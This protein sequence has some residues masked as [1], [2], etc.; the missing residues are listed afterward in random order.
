MPTCWDGAELGNNN[1]HKN[2]MSYTVDGRVAGACPSEFPRRF[3]QIQLFVRI[4]GY[5]GG[6]YTLSDGAT[7]RRCDGA[8]QRIIDRCA[9]EPDQEFD[10]KVKAS[11]PGTFFN[12][13]VP[14]CSSMNVRRTKKEGRKESTYSLDLL[15]RLPHPLRKIA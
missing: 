3:P 13:R 12:G 14:R 10:E 8:L 2:H 1:D 7:V 4:N 6:E 15:D 5:E 11:L 9:F